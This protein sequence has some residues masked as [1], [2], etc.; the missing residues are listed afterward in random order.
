[1]KNK[2]FSKFHRI[3]F[4]NYQLLV[5]V[6]TFYSRYTPPYYQLIPTPDPTDT[7]EQVLDNNM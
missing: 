6:Y 4:L 2:F 7:K 1:M 5:N 3:I